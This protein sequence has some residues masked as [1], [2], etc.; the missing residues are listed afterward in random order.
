M[1]PV[2]NQERCKGCGSCIEICPSEVYQ[3]E[4]DKSNSAHP[5]ECIECWVCVINQS[6]IVYTLRIKS[7]LPSLYKREEF[8]SLEK[9]G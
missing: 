7:L 6:I 5:E 1:Y 8:P 9:R 2:V 4:A 3:M